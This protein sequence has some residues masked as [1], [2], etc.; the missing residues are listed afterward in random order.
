M[1]G[2]RGLDV[3]LRGRVQVN[4]TENEE[5]S[6]GGSLRYDRG[7]DGRGLRFSLSPALGATLQPGLDTSQP[8][9]VASGASRGASLR[10]ELGYG[11]G[12]RGGLWNPF[13]RMEL[14]GDQQRWSTGLLLQWRPGVEFELEAERRHAGESVGHGALFNT[15]LRF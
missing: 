11:M 2:A 9:G 10:G 8:V 13:G 1:Q 6:V 3:E 15:R 7:R 14:Q 12:A 5:H 4:S